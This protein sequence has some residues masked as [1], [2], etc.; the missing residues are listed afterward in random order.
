MFNNVIQF[1]KEVCNISDN[2]ISI[3]IH[4]RKTLLFKDDEAWVKQNEDENFDVPMHCFD[5]AQV[6]KLIRIFLLQQLNDIISKKNLGLYRDDGLEIF[7]NMP[8]LEIE[9][10]KKDLVKVFKDNGLNITVNANV[11]VADFVD[12]NFDL[13]QGIS[14]QRE[15]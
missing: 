6:C 10:K 11:K 3:I 4:S 15:A 7:E 1:A 9:R 12:V 14:G 2:D 8:G 13:V 5:K